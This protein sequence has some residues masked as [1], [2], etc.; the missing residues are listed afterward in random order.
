MT[1]GLSNLARKLAAIGA[2]VL[3]G[4]LLTAAL[5]RMSPGFDSDER[6]L[7]TRLARDSQA[8]ARAEHAA[9]SN[10]VRFYAH[11]LAGMLHG[12][13]GESPSLR[14]PIAEL[15]T[16]RL[17][18]T[19]ELMAFGIVGG[20]LSALSLAL[21]AVAFRRGIAARTASI[22]STFLLCLPPAALAVLI[23][24][25]G[26]PV[27]II[28]ALVLFPRLFDYCRNLLEDAY[29]RP[30]I[31]MARAKGLAPARIFFRHVLPTAAPQF[32]ALA[33]VSVSMAFGACIPVE[34]LCDLPGIG[35]LAWQ[36]AIARDLPVLVSLTMMITIVTLL[37]NSASDQAAV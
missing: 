3:L 17:P 16:Q 10:I 5:V 12:D 35:Q 25:W 21:A 1:P 22:F 29:A 20:W 28:V 11:H 33:G 32:L 14:R 15:I 19:A 23:F 27:R 4:G 7:D 13:L 2:T 37:C 30:H 6:L 24:T 9:N 34:T 36:A 18:V 26:G 31:L 8:A